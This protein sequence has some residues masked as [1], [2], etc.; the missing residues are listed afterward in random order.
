MI[1]RGYICWLVNVEVLV[2]SFLNSTSTTKRYT[3]TRLEQGGVNHRGSGMPLAL[4]RLSSEPQRSR[5]MTVGGYE[6]PS[7]SD[8]DDSCDTIRVSI[9]SG[10]AISS[11]SA[12]SRAGSPHFGFCSDVD[13]EPS[14]P[15]LGPTRWWDSDSGRRRRRRD[16][17]LPFAR[18][19]KRRLLRLARHPLV[20]TQP[21][22]ILFSL[23]LFALFA[24]ILTLFLIYQLNPDKEAL[25]WRSYCALPPAFPPDNFYNLSPAGVF[26]GVF[27]MDSGLER[28][29]FVRTTFAAH[30]RSRVD[31][32]TSRT[33][34]RFIL[35]KPR[36]EWERRIQLEA[37]T[38]NDM[39]ILPI[40][41]NMNN[42]KTH[43]YFSWAARHAWVPPPQTPLP[44]SY[45]N[46]TKIPPS[47]APHDPRPLP[48]SPKEWVRPDFVLKADDDS[49]VM[50]AELEARLRV[51]MH[52]GLNETRTPYYGT[53][54]VVEDPLVYWGYLVKN[55]FMGGEM[56]ALSW[57]LVSWV[58]QSEAVRGLTRG[59]EDKLVAKWMWL[60]PRAGNVRWKSE[61]CWIY[62]H[63]KAGTV[64]SHGFLFPSEVSRIRRQLTN[65]DPGK[66]SPPSVLN[67][68]SYS[69]VSQFGTRYNPP[70][71]NLTPMQSIEALIEGSPM[72][73][74][75]S[76]NHLEDP[77]LEPAM[78]LQRAVNRAWL[79]REGRRVRYQHKKLGG[80]ILV[81]FIKKN[82]W[83]EETA[84]AFLGGDEYVH[85]NI[86]LP[87]GRTGSELPDNSSRSSETE[88]ESS[89]TPEEAETSS[90]GVTVI[91]TTPLV[92]A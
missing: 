49:F 58:A 12:S 4:S 27:S 18:R 35:G 86:P 52:F 16:S 40:A 66:T 45:A 36:P 13:D 44:F 3:I 64:Y 46:Q 59:A 61:H 87:A 84:L 22:T 17:G 53:Q 81:H 82:E 5:G 14:S 76:S 71:P 60:H 34:V 43:A 19:L 74:V 42:G 38:Y 7:S 31:N 78:A 41:E 83:W 24:I 75:G 72:S 6:S 25:P 32:G 48:N 91:T 39:V 15:L 23:V 55:K 21:V 77:S 33:I 47:L 1:N 10:R 65:A 88:S 68:Y 2:Q 69:S 62:D 8:S 57:S 70:S 51:E 37:E 80:T 56:Y 26:L 90:S 29:M 85:S 79:E 20:P 54:P 9:H 11:A 28:R 73:R 89:S 67:T 30:E 92:E 63:P 50:L